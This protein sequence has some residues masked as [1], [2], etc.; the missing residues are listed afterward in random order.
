LDDLLFVGPWPDRQVMQLIASYGAPA[1]VRR[2]R[3]VQ[4][5]FDA[6]VARCRRQREKWLPMVRVRLALLHA[7]AGDWT[8]LSP[9]L[10]DEEQLGILQDLH[11]DLSP[12]LRAAPRP[13]A[14][15]RMLS[16]ALR[17]L[18]D[19]VQCF[20][21]RWGP[22]LESVDLT[23]LNQL[24]NGYNQFYLLEKECV[25]R[26]PRLARQGFRPLPPMTHDELAALFPPLPVP[27]LKP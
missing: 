12:E 5:A 17:E 3:Q 21:R 18:V 8:R 1:F 14:S 4:D 16:R 15:G 27:R 10:V 2:A 9:W 24:R 13:T 22:F 26:S 23:G 7:L 6:V 25:V 20:N 19:S 11:T